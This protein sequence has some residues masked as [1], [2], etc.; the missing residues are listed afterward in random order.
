MLKH[1]CLLGIMHIYKIF[2]FNS[3][4][5]YVLYA[6]VDIGKAMLVA[7]CSL[8][9]HSILFKLVKS[10]LSATCKQLNML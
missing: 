10:M 6:F 2:A 5:V 1:S 3:G 9:S 8:L 7:E 4:L